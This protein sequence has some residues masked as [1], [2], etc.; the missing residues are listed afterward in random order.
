ML[1]SEQNAI[2]ASPVISPACRNESIT[3]RVLFSHPSITRSKMPSRSFPAR[4]MAMITATS[5]RAKDVTFST[6]SEPCMYWASQ[7]L[8]ADENLN[9]SHA[10][11][12]MDTMAMT[13]DMNPLR[14][15]CTT[16]GT[17][18]IKRMISSMFIIALKCLYLPIE[19]IGA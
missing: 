6:C 4:F 10:P 15:P 1:F 11:T 7:V 9:E 12:M 17:K 14:Y 16:A 18:Q 2:M 3:P 13:C 8:V 19:K 5:I